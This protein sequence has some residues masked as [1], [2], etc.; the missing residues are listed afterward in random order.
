MARMVVI[1]KTPDDTAAFDRHYFDVHIPLA[2]KLPGIISYEVSE[3]PIVQLAGASD[4]YL[5]GTLTFDSLDAIKAAFASDIGI[6]C[7]ADRRIL[8]PDDAKVQMFL[9]D[10]REH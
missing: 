10:D 5:I 2:K 4:T 7:A 1:Y 3:R 9:F 6:E 8:E